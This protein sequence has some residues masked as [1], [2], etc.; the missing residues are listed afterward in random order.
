LPRNTFG[1]RPIEQVRHSPTWSPQRSLDLERELA[2]NVNVPFGAHEAAGHFVDRADLLDRQAGIDR[3]QDALVIV[4][5][6]AMIGLDRNNG[7]AQPPRVPHQGAGLDAERLGRV[8]GG[9]GDGG[10]RRNLH[11]DDRLVAQG[12]VFLLLARRKEGVEIEEQPLHRI[13]GR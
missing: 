2:G 1:A 12:R 5:I 8:A 4:G 13:L 10:I 6:E 11:D 9:N 3:L 7:R